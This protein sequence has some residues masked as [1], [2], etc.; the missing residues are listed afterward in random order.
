VLSRRTRVSI[1][2]A[3]RGR[4]AAAAV[5]P[6]IAPVL[7]WSDAR[8]AEELDRYLRLRDAEQAA[9]SAAD[10]ASAAAAYG[11]VMAGQA[12]APGP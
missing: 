8:T 10:D 5:A 12:R 3:D 4:A 1:E 11:A 7:A 9:E 2:A 6:L